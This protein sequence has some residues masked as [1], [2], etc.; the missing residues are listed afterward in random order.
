MRCLAVLVDVEQ[1]PGSPSSRRGSFGDS[2]AAVADRQGPAAPLLRGGRALLCCTAWL[3][4]RALLCCTAWLCDR[5]FLCCR[6]VSSGPCCRLGVRPW[7]RPH[8]W[9]GLRA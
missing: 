1:R 4:D 8:R 5:A 6:A 9:L 7:R 2:P 3:C